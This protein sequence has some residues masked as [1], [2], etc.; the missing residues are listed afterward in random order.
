[1]KVRGGNFGAH[2]PGAWLVAVI[3]AVASL[4]AGQYELPLGAD[5][6]SELFG[7]HRVSAGEVLVAFRPRPDLARLRADLDA[8][9]DA[10]VGDGRVWRVHSRSRKVGALLNALAARRDVVYAE[11]N[12]VLYTTREPND[13]RFPELW[14]LKNI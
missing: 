7:T 11:P 2:R 12:Y 13:P 10:I 14:G 8:D 1:M 5:R 9:A 4:T 6:S 3:V